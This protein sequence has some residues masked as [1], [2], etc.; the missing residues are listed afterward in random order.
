MIAGNSFQTTILSATAGFPTI[1]HLEVSDFAGSVIVAVIKFAV[2]NDTCSD[3]APHFEHCQTLDTIVLAK[4]ELAQ[5]GHLAIIGDVN[6]KAVALGE[7][8]AQGQILPVQID[9]GAD[10]AM[11]GIHQAWGANAHAENGRCRRFD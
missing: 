3:A 4:C 10:D 6:G 11:F 1:N 2:D 5:G 7:H 8:L 9:G